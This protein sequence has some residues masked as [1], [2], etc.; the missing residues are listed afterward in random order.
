MQ[1]RTCSSA[2][3]LRFFWT[4]LN[5]F[6]FF[7]ATV[8]LFLPGEICCVG[9]GWSGRRRGTS[10]GEQPDRGGRSPQT[11]T[12]Q[13]C[14]VL[15]SR[16]LCL[17]QSHPPRAAGPARRRL[18]GHSIS[19]GGV[20]EPSLHSALRSLLAQVGSSLARCIWK[21]VRHRC[22]ESSHHLHLRGQSGMPA[23]WAL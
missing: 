15:Y 20:F 6:F 11:S 1:K 3:P 9:Y 8:P 22:R 5:N 18:T 21:P 16:A 7:Q 10:R 14:I 23:R 4:G 12:V 19:F 2:A 13:Y 17:Q